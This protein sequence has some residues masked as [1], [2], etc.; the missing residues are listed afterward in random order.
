MHGHYTTI[1][2]DRMS[3]GKNTLISFTIHHVNVLFFSSNTFLLRAQVFSFFLLSHGGC[4]YGH[5]IL[6]FNF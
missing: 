2:K 3:R 4:S 5:V 6:Y 1:G